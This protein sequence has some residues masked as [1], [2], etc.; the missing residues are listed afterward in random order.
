M[1]EVLTISTLFGYVKDIISLNKISL[2]ISSNTKLQVKLLDQDI[3][4][5]YIKNQ[6]K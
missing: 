2:N 3:H 5:R 1:V 6:F 4:I